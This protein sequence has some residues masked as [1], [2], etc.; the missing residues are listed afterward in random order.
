MTKTRPSRKIADEMTNDEFYDACASLLGCKHEGRA[1]PLL[2]RNRWINRIPGSGRFP[3]RG[4]IR[5]FGEQVHVALNDPP[6]TMIG[7]KEEV[8]QTLRFTLS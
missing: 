6:L 1:E 2:K 3:G 4:I 5:V 7:T 8:L